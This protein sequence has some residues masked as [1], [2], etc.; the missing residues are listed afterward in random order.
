MKFEYHPTPDFSEPLN[1]RLGHY[2]RVPDITWDFFRWWGCWI[3][4][5]FI[6][7]QFRLRVGGKLPDDQRVAIVA[8]HQSHL[9]TATILAA[10]PYRRRK[11]LVVLA[12][13]DYF[14]QS[15]P[16]AIM[17]SL[18]CQGVAF[19]RLHWTAIRGWYKLLKELKAGWILFY[20][21]GSRHSKEI[22]SGLLKI[23]IK[24]GWTVLPVRL[25]GAD[26]AWPPH[27]K[28]WRPLHRLGVNFFEPYRGH[29]LAELLDKLKG[30]LYPS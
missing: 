17:A 10:L 15:S 19:D 22:Q 9:D 25:D 2:P 26:E 20:P 14:F 6:R 18:L 30:E 11:N 7:A 27:E 5:L 24:E 1:K 28:C 8:N 23:L 13:E 4:V 16:K 29:D 12:A 3:S 21:S